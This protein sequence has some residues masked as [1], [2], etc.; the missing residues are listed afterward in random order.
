[1]LLTN[2]MESKKSM[3]QMIGYLVNLELKTRVVKG[4]W[5]FKG[6]SP[7]GEGNSYVVYVVTN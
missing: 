6:Q 7:T 3:G 2:T 5:W 1:M 4:N